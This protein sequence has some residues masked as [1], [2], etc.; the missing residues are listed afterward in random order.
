VLVGCSD[1]APKEAA[2]PRT[3]AAPFAAPVPVAATSS[4]QLTAPGGA[5]AEF[6]AQFKVTSLRIGK[7]IPSSLEGGSMDAAAIVFPAFDVK[8]ECL[9]DVTLVVPHATATAAGEVAAYASA[10]TS[11]AR[12][13]LPPTNSGGPGRVLDNRPRALVKARAGTADLRFDVTAIARLW[14]DGTGFPSE[15]RAVPPGT[16]FVLVLRPPAADAG[17]YAVTTDIVPHLD[18]RRRG[19]C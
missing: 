3:T 8:G 11:L 4:I 15:G 13:E 18:V 5:F 16:P 17:T 2:I 7:D 6:T 12:N 14:A 1:A 9:V 10:A 19:D